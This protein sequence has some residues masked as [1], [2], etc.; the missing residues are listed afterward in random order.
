M[1]IFPPDPDFEAL[2]L[3]LTRLRAARGWSYDQLAAR[4]GL[5]RRTLIEIE[6]GRTIGTLKTWHALAH[7]LST[8]LDE[9]FA[10]LCNGHEPPGK[11]GD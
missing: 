1:T 7:A 9:L 11:A 8:P 10:T 5:G 6:Q 2:R 3:E 4:S